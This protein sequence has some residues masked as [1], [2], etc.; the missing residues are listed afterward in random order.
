MNVFN[1]TALYT[2]G[3][4]NA[5]YYVYLTTKHTHTQLLYNSNPSNS[6]IFSSNIQVFH[7]WFNQ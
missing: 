2:Y 4:K 7:N 3:G 6:T 5:Q 1:A